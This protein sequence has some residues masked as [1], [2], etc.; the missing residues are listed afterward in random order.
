MASGGLG[1]FG[2]LLGRPV[3]ALAMGLALQLAPSAAPAQEVLRVPLVVD[4]GTFDPDNGFEIGAMSAM[5]NVYEGLVEYEPG[6]AK[7]AGRLATGWEISADGLTYTFHLRD[8]VKFHD[9]TPLTADAV[10]RSF[11]RRRDGKLILSYFLANVA[12]I[13]APDPAT[14]VLTLGHRQPS[15]LDGLASAWGPKVISPAALAE[16]D[17]GDAAT[18][19]L[20]EH[21]DGTGPFKLAEFNRGEDYVFTRN[22]DYWGSKPFFDEIRMPVIPDISQQILQLQAGEI[23]AVPDGYPVAQLGNLPAG[24][25]ITAVPSMTQFELF[26]KPGTP[27]DDP[28]VRNAVLTAI[29]PALWM[30]DI[31]GDYAELSK[32]L[33]QNAMLTP[34]HPVQFPTDFA[35]A[36]AAVAKYGNVQL[37]IGIQSE[38]AS[39][40]PI[41]ELMVAQLATIGVK[42]GVDVLPIGA[43]YAMK[44]DPKAPDM[45][46]TIANPDAAH[47]ENQ[48]KTYF[49]KDG[50]VNYYGRSLPAAEALIDQAGL[51]TDIPQRNALYEQASQIYV[52]AGYF[53]PLVDVEDVIVHARGLTDLGLRPAFPQGNIDYGTVRWAD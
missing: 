36:K 22:A 13:A 42:A 3:L 37:V 43:A 2:Q 11:E 53:I 24:L 30:K 15:L 46:L 8:G 35:A 29:N 51:L 19:W 47:P 39:Y 1:R 5:N 31:F 45:L 41:A 9:G 14:V 20:N 21:A 17:N 48:A 33:F 28:Q 38:V 50:A 25:E 23:D 7:I 12:D 18:T 52:D 32:S 49:V 40:A 16:H 6:T 26:V 4:I 27:M 10:K 34:A 44:G